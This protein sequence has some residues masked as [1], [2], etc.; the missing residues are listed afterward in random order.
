MYG[1][2]Y[3]CLNAVL[4]QCR[5]SRVIQPTTGWGYTFFPYR[6]RHHRRQGS[7]GGWGYTTDNRL[8]LYNRQQVGVTPFSI[9]PPPLPSPWR[10]RRRYGKKV[11]FK[12][13]SMSPRISHSGKCLHTYH[14]SRCLH[15][16][17]MAVNVSMHT[18]W[19]SMSA[20]ISHSGKCLHA[21]HMTVNV[22]T[23]ITLCQMSP[24]ISHW[25]KCLHTYHMGVNVSIHITQR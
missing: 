12:L 5:L 14:I 18:T 3:H 17:H 24:Y 6:R 21:C 1:D 23:H 15:A 25:R 11:F 16:Y 13:C 9:P 10:W 8:G 4:P 19:R 2:I 22:Y 20:Y 7:S